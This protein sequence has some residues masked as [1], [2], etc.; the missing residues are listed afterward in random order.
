M[1][2]YLEQKPICKTD[3]EAAIVQ[4]K[5]I[6]VNYEKEKIDVVGIYMQHSD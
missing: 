1:K 3:P 5:R 6:Q 2:K 4:V